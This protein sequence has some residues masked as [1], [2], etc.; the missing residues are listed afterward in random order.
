MTRRAPV[1]MTWLLGA[2]GA[3]LAAAC[4]SST[5]PHQP[6]PCPS[7]S[8]GKAAG[9]SLFGV[10]QL[11]SYCIDTLPAHGPP[12]DTGHVTLKRATPADSITA[13][14]ATQGQSPLNVAG[15]YTLSGT[16]SIHVTGN[17][18]TPLGPVGVE[19]LG[20]FLLQQNTLSV[21]GRL[22][23]TGTS[24]RPLSFIGARSGP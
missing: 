12:A 20:R 6:A 16:D 15:T 14:F 9:D 13:V 23:V 22:L 2:V 21:S 18:I 1:R 11:A 17:V 19:L 5:N 10:Y 3:A 8:G 7:Y 4:G 24:P